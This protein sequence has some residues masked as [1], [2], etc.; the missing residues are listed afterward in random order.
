MERKKEQACRCIVIQWFYRVQCYRDEGRIIQRM[1]S[2]QRE[3]TPPM[4]KLSRRR[5]ELIMPT[6]ELMP[7]I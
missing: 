4:M 5:R 1:T 2:T 6:S 7:G 3:M